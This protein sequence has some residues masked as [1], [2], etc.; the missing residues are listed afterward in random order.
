VGS[1]AQPTRN[2]DVT[3][4]RHGHT[5]R[6]NAAPQTA[7]PQPI[8]CAAVVVLSPG[9]AVLRQAPIPALRQAPTRR[10]DWTGQTRPCPRA[11]PRRR[12]DQSEALPS[13]RV[14]LHAD[15]R[16][17]DPLGLPLPSARFH[18]RLIPAVFARHR[19][20]RRAS[21][22]PAQTMHTCRPPYP[23]RTRQAIPGTRPD[24][25]GLR[26]DMSGSAPPLYL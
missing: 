19:L 2:Q 8:A 26:R 10:G 6:G 14:M 25:H 9:T 1:R 20:S 12:R 17:Y 23:G 11:C 3:P 24:G 21:P 15:R 4:G 18:H 13:R 5:G 7:W 16:Y 22:V